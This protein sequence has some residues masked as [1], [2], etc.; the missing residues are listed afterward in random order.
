MPTRFCSIVSLLLLL[1]ASGPAAL[2]AA[3]SEFRAD[4]LAAM[5]A[6]IQEAI[7]DRKLPGG[8]LRLE[9][10]GRVYQK[11]FG[12]RAIVPVAEAMAEDTIFDAAS[13]TKV[14]ATTPS[15]LLLAERGKIDLDAPVAAYVPEFAQNGKAAIAVRHLLTHTSGLRPG[16]G[17]SPSWSGYDGAIQRACEEKPRSEPGTT[18]VYS[19]INFIVLGEIV[20]RVSGERL[21]EFV[22]REIFR[23]LKMN[24]SGYLPPADKLSRIAP[25]EFDSEGKMLRGIVHDPTARKMG[26]V[27]G[28]AGVFTTVAD[29]ARF[30][31]M[32][33]NHGELDGVRLL[34]PA[35]V[36][37]MTGVQTRDDISRRG[38]GWDI[39]SPHSGPRGKVFPLGSYGHTGWTGSS[40]WLD[41][42][43]GSIVIFMS[44]RVHPDGK[45]N[46]VP[47]RATLGT[48]AAEATGFDFAH[49]DRKQVTPRPKGEP[50]FVLNGIDVLVR[51]HFIRLR[52]LKVGLITN[53]TG[54]DR[55]RNASTDLLHQAPGVE[56]NAL[57]SPEHGIRGTADTKVGDSVDEK[58]GLPIYSLYGGAARRQPGQ[59]DADYDLAVIR[60]HQPKLEQIRELDALIFDVQD[61]GARFYTYSS[62]LGA[63]LEA[64][65]QAGKKIYVLDRVNPITG[66]H[67]EGPVQTRHFSFIGFHT[68]PVRHGLTMGE[69]A[70]MLNAE[71][72][73]KADLAVVAC[74]NWSRDTWFDGT[75]LPWTNPSPS[76]RSLNAA[77]LYPGICLL[78]SASV[79]M[80]RGTDKPFE[81][82]GAPYIDDT[83]LAREMNRAGLTGVRFVPVR[84][85]PRVEYFPGPPG[86]L[87]YRDQECG[88]VYM[89]L[90][91]RERCNVVDIG[92]VMA[93]VLQ[94]LHPQEFN[95]DQMARLLGHD[96]TLQAIKA[97]KT[98]AEIKAL[99]SRDLEQYRA[100][101]QPFLLYKAAN[102]S[103]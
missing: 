62:T 67:V 72:G 64:A 33:L 35:T 84:F 9:R 69:L 61:I 86:S 2:G 98:L 83:R 75:D 79:S 26:G 102:G 34:A 19:D 44:N 5:D 23:P 94:R 95:P 46:V 57:F 22:A 6:A 73:F 8:V 70:L 4:K 15:I 87:K 17:G 12:R 49:V 52:G 85:T 59:S 13:L 99:W 42:S 50:T 89:V 76:M 88:G 10:N 38:F 54:R 29:L 28:H 1:A 30:A 66:S 91:D 51:E 27:A 97:G 81:Q 56:L 60:S 103:R 45:G 71:R 41:P 74:E 21:D 32:M 92:I 63:A 18:F 16:I 82:A 77:T 55:E 48:L 39:D 58:T 40:V 101:R 43:S 80:G 53:H 36:Q 24:D 31:H 25:T 11:A 90:T 14:L 37:R 20:R 93:Q 68:L 100:R 47:L 78:E 65:G 7:T 3:G 96:E